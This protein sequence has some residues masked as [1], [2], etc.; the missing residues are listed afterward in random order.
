[1]DSTPTL[2]NTNG[3]GARVMCFTHPSSSQ[4]IRNLGLSRS[5]SSK[6]SFACKPTITQSPRYANKANEIRA[7]TFGTINAAMMNGTERAPLMTLPHSA[8]NVPMLAAH[9]L[10]AAF[11]TTESLPALAAKANHRLTGAY[12]QRFFPS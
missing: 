2:K 4:N 1:M 9:F 12:E 6:I 3:V 11:T 8:R 10:M 5:F 7:D